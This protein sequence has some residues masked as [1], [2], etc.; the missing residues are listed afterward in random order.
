[1]VWLGTTDSLLES[2][3]YINQN[4]VVWTFPTPLLAWCL[5]VME[6]AW[7]PHV[8]NFVCT[9]EEEEVEIMK[10]RNL[11]KKGKHLKQTLSNWNTKN[12][13]EVTEREA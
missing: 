9:S 5:R 12:Y 3:Q 8:S 6:V 11:R 1:M 7:F 10:Y 13:G 4:G 2:E